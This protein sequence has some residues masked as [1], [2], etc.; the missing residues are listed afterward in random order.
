MKKY[1]LLIILILT[2][3]KLFAQGKKGFQVLIGHENDVFGPN[4]RDE[5]YTGGL[6]LEVL[7]PQWGQFWQPFFRFKQVKSLNIQRIAFGGTGYTPQ[8][9]A[10]STIVLNDR[11]YASLVYGSIGNTSY[12]PTNKWLVQSDLIIGWMGTKSPGQLQ[13]YLH[14]NNWLG[15]TRP[16]PLGWDNQ[17]GFDGAMIANYNTRVQ[18]FLSDY[19]PKSKVSFVQTSLTG[20]LDVGTYMINL[21]GGFK[22]NLLNWNSSILHDY[23]PSHPTFN[24]EDFTVQPKKLRFNLF[25]EPQMRLAAYNAT[26]EGLMFTDNSVYTIPSSEVNRL[27]FE[28]NTGINIQFYDLIYVKYMLFLRSREF[29]GGKPLHAW[30]GITL[31]LSPSRWNN[32]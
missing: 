14:R 13:A 32:N 24:E 29:E 9:L 22:L 4:N 25:I 18:Y 6:K 28:L 17:I 16:V 11:P 15:S 5:N 10:A 2:S 30:G 26:L 27:L 31:G 19:N 8:D 3:V 7:T 23:N 1:I 20:R 21:Q 12:S